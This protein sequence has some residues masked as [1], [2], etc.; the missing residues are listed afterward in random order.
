MIPVLLLVGCAEYRT[1][2]L[3]TLRGEAGSFEPSGVALLEDGRMV[4]VAEGDATHLLV[5]DRDAPV[6]AGNLLGVLPF[7]DGR[8]D[9]PPERPRCTDRHYRA[10]VRLRPEVIEWLDNGLPVPYNVEDLAPFGPNRV[11]GVTEY[12]TIGRKTGYRRDYQTRSR[13]QTERIFVLERNDGAWDELR[14][15]EIDR[16]RDQL[17]D[18]G[19]ATCRDDMLVEGLATD[20]AGE[21]I[22][23]GL[24]RCDGPVQ[25]VLSYDL[26]AARR[27]RAV[28]LEVEADGI[29]D[30][31]AGP[32]EG[33][34]GLTYAA[35]HLY[36]TTAWDSWGYPTEA[37]FGGRVH[38]VD[39]GR[40]H[41]IDLGE[42][43]RDRPSG[44][45]I[46]N[47]PGSSG[48]PGD[49]DTLVVFDNDA[50]AGST[51]RPNVTL[52][53][54]RTPRPEQQA[55]SQ[56]LEVARDQNPLPLALNGF[57]FR[58]YNRDHR[59]G[60]LA[61]TLDVAADGAPGA[62]T[63]AV[64]GLWQIQ[65]GGTLGNLSTLLPLFGKTLGHDKQAVA[66]SDFSA[67][68]LRFSTYDVRVSVIPRDRERQN[69]SVARL[70]DQVRDGYVLTVPL[71]EA[72]PADAG[73]V[74]QGFSID[75]SS[76]ADRGICLAAM[77]L[78]VDWHDAAHDAVDV[79]STLI[80]GLC[81][82]FDT[83]GNNLLHGRT[84]DV[85]GGVEVTLKFAVA[86]G[87]PT[88]QWSARVSD[89]RVPAPRDADG[90]TA[91]DPVAVTTDALAQAHLH[92]MRV[93]GSGRFTQAERQPAAPPAA[94]L[95]LGTQ[96]DGNP[97]A[98]SAGL[99]GFALAL[100]P[101]GFD[102]RIATR[103]LTETEALNRNN[104]VHQYLVR[105]FSD[106]SGGFLEGGLTHG[107]HRRGPM[108][109]NQRPSALLL[110][111]DLTSFPQLDHPAE[112]HD[113]LFDRRRT[114]PNLLPEDGFVRWSLSPTR[115]QP[116]R[117]SS[118]W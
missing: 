94:W 48:A 26:G 65:I 53:V 58:W 62:W 109:D 6:R 28:T 77:E 72:F 66:F 116:P 78:G 91:F 61:A 16:L 84:T 68:G 9:C 44:L 51:T 102:P 27:G 85:A 3:L 118:P 2:P 4:V 39:G 95:D 47:R 57:D 107:I 63:R 82:D 98:A 20:P 83:R 35:G 21:R 76:R 56:L 50:A 73:L 113:I 54:A 7:E 79:V 15:P 17:S 114:D 105:A 34:S 86:E 74:L 104:Y 100:D 36:A 59:L 14:L 110:G 103:P 111:V 5:P 18:W 93:D 96:I 117:C 13:R 25:R 88:A 92:C 42:P 52:L 37:V 115:T 43:F 24:R 71:S 60:Q 112:V 81:N 64:G 11:L 75:T 12:S 19:R 101:A 106:P 87:T 41:P 32:E 46:V 67:S 29:A 30:G 23:I 40:L 22:W 55:W 97:A 49:L 31:T 8:A 89:R 90:N 33:L 108:R 45:A 70:L 1:Y 38:E 80:G 99:R 10:Q 69:P